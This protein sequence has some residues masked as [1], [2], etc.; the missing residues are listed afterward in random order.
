MQLDAIRLGRS[1]ALFCYFRL[2]NYFLAARFRS[3]RRIKGAAFAQLLYPAVSAHL[4]NL[5]FDRSRQHARRCADWK[6]RGAWTLAVACNFHVQ[7]PSNLTS[8]A[9]GTNWASVYDQCRRA[10]LFHLSI[11][12][13]LF[14]AAAA[15][16][17]ALDLSGS[18]TRAS[19]RAELGAPAN[20]SETPVRDVVYYFGPAHFDAFSAGA[21]LALLRPFVTTR[22]DQARF[23]LTAA[24]G[25]AAVHACAYL[26]IDAS[27]EGINKQVLVNEFNSYAAGGG[28]EIVIYTVVIGLASGLISLILAGEGLLVAFCHLQLL[29][30][31]GRVSYGAYVYH[32]PVLA[33][34]DVIWPDSFVTWT[35]TLSRFSTG[36]LA[37]L[38]IALLSFRYIEAPVLRLRARFS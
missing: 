17:G 25:V 31:I 12:V 29:R 38:L 14:A 9:L 20:W 11:P 4:A 5:C 37:T 27:A 7:L 8:R 18:L 24:L 22:L 2:R 26:G 33:L 16:C 19:R 21:L 3:L 32:V 15:Y 36:Y 28:R 30:P 13:C 35:G 34:Y 23:F 6:P 1:L 10:I